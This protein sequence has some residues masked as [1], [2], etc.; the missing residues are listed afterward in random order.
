MRAPALPLYGAE[1]GPRGAGKR[2]R[3]RPALPPTPLL[4]AGGRA[5]P[6]RRGRRTPPGAGEPGGLRPVCHLLSEPLCLNNIYV[7]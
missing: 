2:P 3:V 7:N 1:W 6:D 4:A 5:A